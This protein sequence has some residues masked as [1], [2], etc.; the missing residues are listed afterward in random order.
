MPGLYFCTKLGW[1]SYIVSITEIASKKIGTLIHYTKFL[2]F[3]VALYL[4]KSIL[5][6]CMECC[7]YVCVDAPNG[8]L[9]MLE[10]VQKGL[11]GTVG[12]LLAFSV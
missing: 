10:K 1:F 8:F 6:P 3:D 4:Y 7:C 9:D 5:Q 12:P 11:Y 2:S